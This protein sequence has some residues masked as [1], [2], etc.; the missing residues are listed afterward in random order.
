MASSL[1]DSKVTR[2]CN[3]GLKQTNKQYLQKKKKCDCENENSWKYLRSAVNCFYIYKS[4]LFR[5]SHHFAVVMRDRWVHEKLISEIIHLF[6]FEDGDNFVI[7]CL[8]HDGPP[9]GVRVKRFKLY[10]EEPWI[11]KSVQWRNK[12][13]RPEIF[14]VTSMNIQNSGS[15]IWAAW[16]K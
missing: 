14:F 5:L 16:W 6:K 15:V 1:L 10:T 13:I 4:R 12:K 9:G 8:Y 3:S 2:H 11:I 7:S